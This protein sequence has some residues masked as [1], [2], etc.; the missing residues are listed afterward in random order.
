MT[1]TS[2]EVREQLEDLLE[3][4]LLGPADGP[5]EELPAGTIPAERYLLGRLVP[6]V[7]D[8]GGAIVEPTVDDADFAE[9]DLVDQDV[10][11]DAGQS[12]DRESEKSTRAG[13]MASSALGLSF[14]VPEGVSHVL[15]E[16]TWGRYGR[17]QSETQVTEQ[18]RARTV[19]RRRPCGG[20]VEVPVD[21]DGSG[22][23]TPDPEQDGVV[24][25]WTVRSHDRGRGRVRIVHV[26]LVNGLPPLA[27]TPDVN[28][29]YQAG[30]HVTALDG[31]SA[32]FVGHNDPELVAPSPIRDDERAHLA[33][34]HRATRKYATGSH[35]A[36]DADVRVDE[37]RAWRLRTTCFPSAE[38][39][40][41]VPGDPDRMPGVVLD[42]SRLG[43]PE[44]AADGLVAGLAPLVDGYRKWL[45]EQQSR[46]SSTPGGEGGELADHLE[47]ARLAVDEANIVADRLGRA[48]ELLRINGQA[49]EAFRF[50]NQAMAWQRV[51]GELVRRRAAEPDRSVDDLLR[52]LDIPA[53]RSWR[54]FQLAFVLL[55]LPGLTDPQHP[56]AHRGADDGHVQ[57]LFFPTG[58]GKTEAYLGLTAYTLAIRRLQ[59]VVGTGQDA[60]DGSDGVGVLMRYTLRLL[61]AQQ[62]QRAAA[63]IC[64]C[65]QLRRERIDNGDRRWGETPFRLGLWV[66]SAVTPN[67]YEE[68][69]RQVGEAVGR[70]AATGGVLQLVACPWC[71]S[72]LSGGNDVRT[73]DARRRV[74][75][76]CSDPD[77]RCPFTPARSPGEGLP[78]VTVDEEV[79]RL[80]PA[81]VIST[82]D[83]LA[84]LPWK[85][86]TAPLFGLV[87]SRCSRHGW[88]TPDTATWCRT[89]HPATKYL[90]AV[91]AE[92][93]MRL[94]PPDLVIQDELHLISDALGSIVGLFETVVDRL[95]S[96]ED[97]GRRI[98]PVLVASTATVRSARDQVKQVFDRGLTVFPPQVIDAGDT[99]FSRRVPPSSQ[100]PGRR[101]RGICVPGERMKS[102]SIRVMS[103]LLEHGQYL[104]DH[105]GS[106]AD[107]Y[108]TLVGYFTSTR[109]LAGTRRLVDDDIAERL[110]S[111]QVRTRR[112]VPNVTELTSRMPSTQITATLADLEREFDP[113]HDSTSA[114]DTF[115]AMTAAER[116]ARAPRA[117]PVDVLL[118]TSMLQVGV[119]VPRLGLM[120]VSGQPK[121]TAEYIQ[122]TSR[123]GRTAG[124]PGLV[125]TVFQWARPRDLAHY[126]SFAY[127][128]ET[129][130]MTVEGVTTTPFSDRALDRGLTAVIAT[131]VRHSAD[132]ALPN[133]AAHTVD[134]AGAMAERLVDDLARRAERV[135]ADTRWGDEVRSM[136]RARLDGWRHR[137][138]H[139]PSGVLGYRDADGVTGLLRDPNDGAWDGWSVPFSLREVE[140][141]VLLQLDG[142][143]RSLDTAPAWDY[144]DDAEVR[145]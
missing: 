75:I 42:M 18:E 7:P 92:P 123:V 144:V 141:E 137:R 29:L 54:P 25:T 129:F 3:K 13:S 85:A 59:G 50:A 93:A 97:Q 20:P 11:V 101:Y 112:R 71:G 2:F 74:L 68:A 53:N 60:R 125:V 14:M 140:A 128:H 127:D 83:K 66:G 118:A 114:M 96:R 143:D 35:C 95:T 122:A 103:A 81:L 24:V 73:D 115:R 88:Q 16:A 26:A 120:L 33:L 64:A 104:L 21:T 121:N 30:L 56:D 90:P 44:L 86:G 80:T 89:N 55:C 70:G 99:F 1:K 17:T 87:T 134:L 43:S 133:R 106:A 139:L 132:A 63:L 105:H 32:I 49:R 91:E 8:D 138:T 113:G 9:V 84:Q 117:R 77:G 109:D 48:V 124:R 135:T 67:S 108:Q 52:E 40:P 61:T 107:P 39:A 45:G 6:R 110:R 4:D 27:Q 31:G 102:V 38:V 62:F 19:W 57:L 98:R 145:L 82:V 69:K 126:E 5:D 119:D 41:V 136:A 131:A 23:G 28:R 58:G 100:T 46:L 79:Y 116:D 142:V 37:R 111:N 130:G 15:V 36:V 10:T 22:S 51:R 47:V 78:V 72:P 76:F 65:E 94:R 12:D 34:L